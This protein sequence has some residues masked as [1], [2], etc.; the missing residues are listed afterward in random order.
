V[1][2][3]TDTNE[4]HRSNSATPENQK[5]EF[6]DSK[7]SP[8]A[9]KKRS[10]IAPLLF[11]FAIL[12]LVVFMKGDSL[13]QYIPYSFGDSHNDLNNQLIFETRID[14]I[15]RSRAPAIKPFSLDNFRTSLDDINLRLSK[16]TKREQV[17][18]P[19]TNS[20][21]AHN[22]DSQQVKKDLTEIVS[23]NTIPDLAP[24]PSPTTPVPKLPNIPDNI[25]QSVNLN[26]GTI[27]TRSNP[28]GISNSRSTANSLKTNPDGRV[29]GPPAISDPTKGSS[30]Q[31]AL[32][33]S[34]LQ[35]YEV[36]RYDQPQIYET[37]TAT[38]VLAAPSLLSQSITRLKS[39]TPIHVTARMG[40]WLELI[41]NEG[42]IGYI[43]AQDAEK[44]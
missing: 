17:V 6:L 3:D 12:G 40:L 10:L 43:F 33:G 44:K 41:S 14:N 36:E 25:G 4:T 38:N 23:L 34:A 16:L 11:L 22:D 27:P 32:D 20:S 1:L 31:R 30:N 26:A 18:L 39:E 8:E 24:S 5:S 13:K 15:F 19:D 7:D 29:F 9:P 2:G 35:S 37:I 21:D 42:K 28:T